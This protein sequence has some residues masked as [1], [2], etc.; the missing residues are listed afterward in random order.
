MQGVL[1][2]EFFLL[3]LTFF[4]IS[5]ILSDNQSEYRMFRKNNMLVACVTQKS[6]Y[7]CPRNEASSRV[8][9]LQRLMYSHAIGAYIYNV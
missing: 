9:T 1:S 7:L 3:L 8:C 6:C 5:L 4:M 2:D